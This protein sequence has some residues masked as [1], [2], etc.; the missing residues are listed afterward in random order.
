MSIPYLFSHSNA[1]R[2]DI[3]S[4]AVA[5]LEILVYFLTTHPTS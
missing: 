1:D 2:L 5:L 3:G 4:W